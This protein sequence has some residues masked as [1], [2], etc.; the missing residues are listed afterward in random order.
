[1]GQEQEVS[2]ETI[3][4]WV[5]DSSDIVALH[6]RTK[7]LPVEGDGAVIFPPTYATRDNE[8]LEKKYVIDRLSDGTKIAQIDSVGSQANRMEPLFKTEY[9]NLVPQINIEL[10][11][12]K[13]VSLLDSGHRL[14]DALVRSTAELNDKSKEAFRAFDEDGNAELIAKLS[15]T[16][17][18][19]GVWD[20]RGNYAKIPRLV[21]SV[22][23]AWD[24]DVV[25]RAATYIPPVD[26]R[27]EE[28]FDEN[29][30][31]KKNE[32]LSQRGF[33]HAP[34][35]DV[36][37]VIAHGGIYKDVTINL[38]ALRA[39]KS[40]NRNTDT[41]REYILGLTLVAATEPQD[42][43]LRQGCLLTPDP[44]VPAKW[45]LVRRNGVRENISLDH[46]TGVAFAK[47]VSEK[48][49]VGEGGE[50]RFDKKLAQKDVEEN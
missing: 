4:N 25:H 20:S 30:F 35:N 1:M 28:V 14:G 36:G 10:D 18:V 38:V 12:G 47:S 37:G 40:A 3:S 9:A 15:P 31:E 48:F 7:L 13:K 39:L 41:L 27:S 33:Q 5:D 21:N 16:S 6:F 2:L 34:S 11:S 8:P 44:D 22:I 17:L 50:Y 24:V 43:F 46:N 32:K 45:K 19:F 29:T 42:G 23:R 26:Y 49:G